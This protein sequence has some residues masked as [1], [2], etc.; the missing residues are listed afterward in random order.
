MGG[1][2]ASTDPWVITKYKCFDS[3]LE[4]FDEHV[5]IFCVKIN[6]P[7]WLPQFFFVRSNIDN[8]TNRS[9]VYG[10]WLV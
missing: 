4:S 2:C 5:F 1:H 10:S 8:R 3:T 9:F 7:F 6:D